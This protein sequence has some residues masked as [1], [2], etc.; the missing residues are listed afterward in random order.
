[1]KYR[2]YSFLMT[3]L[4][5]L[6]VTSAAL[7][8]SYSFRV[9]KEV[10]R[11][12]VNADGT[13]ALD[14]VFEFQNE[15]GAHAIDF[16]DVGLPNS[17]YDFNSIS[18]DVDGV[19]V[20]ISSDYQGDGGSGV[21]VDMGGQ[22]IAPGQS[23]VVHVHV[24]KVE[25]MIF[26]DDADET[27]ASMEFM[28]TYFGSAY[29]NGQTNLTMI[30]IL[31]S[32]VTSDQP[33]YH[34]ARGGWPGAS[35]PVIAQNS[36]GNLTYTW[37]SDSASAAGQYTFG[38]S[39][40]ASAVPE[41]AIV[42]TT[43]FD[44]LLG[45]IAAV[46]VGGFFNILPFCCF[47]GFFFG[48]PILGAVQE[49][50]RKLQYMSPK[51]SIE[52]HG[53]KRGLTAVEAAVLMETPLDKVMTMI[54]FGV[55]KKGAAEVVRR[56]PL[57]LKISEPQPENLRG[58]EKSFV[59]AFAKPD[60][61]RRKDLQA[62]VVELVRSVEEKMKG[63]SKKETQEYY[64]SI[65]DRAWTQIEA[66][67]TPEVKSQMAE[68]ALE[69]TMLDKN[70]DDRSRRVFTGPMYA[71]LWWGRYDPGYGGS[72]ASGSGGGSAPMSMPT[73]S[74]GRTALPGA[75]FASSVI[76]NTQTFAQKVLGGTDT[77]TQ[78]ITKVTN[79][80]PVSTS[81]GGGHSGGGGCACACAGCACA[82]AGGGR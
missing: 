38:A 27:Y 78:G 50:K 40:P 39:F 7:A 28:P 52:G 35:E 69:W 6:G 49:R 56:D 61:A 34:P 14:Y 81:S 43:A 32:G 45:G 3:I 4:L 25:R 54:L 63:F 8:Q 36:Q 57:Q 53:I 44:L 66:A 62:L 80:P 77:F 29:V 31:P 79:P 33:R 47:G 68:E 74:G 30:L 58:Y 51:I 10:V 18:A 11:V 73:T 55:V 72:A 76:T 60:A 5:A 75:A 70:Y 13:L 21:S 82:C 2:I 46:V 16:V 23:G 42:R 48:L 37:Q 64:K 59:A 22:A 12:F 9:P 26:P 19:P 20:S 24:G 41:S 1:M 15:S 71:P 67:N 17:N 65:N